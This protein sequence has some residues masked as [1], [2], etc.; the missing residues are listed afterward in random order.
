M[1]AREKAR[2]REVGPGGREGGQVA[3]PRAVLG[4]LWATTALAVGGQCSAA[5]IGEKERGRRRG[6]G[7]RT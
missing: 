4:D 7:P 6:V 1:A 3:K 5:D 2:E